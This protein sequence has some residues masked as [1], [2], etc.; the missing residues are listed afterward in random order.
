MINLSIAEIDNYN[1]F[2]NVIEK[3]RIESRRILNSSKSKIVKRYDLYCKKNLDIIFP[4]GDWDDQVKTHLVS[5]YGSNVGLDSAKEKI[6]GAFIKEMKFKC[7][8]CMVNSS[9]TFDHYFDKADYP[10]YSIFTPNLIPCCSQ[11]NS[12]K[13]T[14]MF[15]ANGE[16]LFIHFYYDVIPMNQFLFIRFHLD[17]DN[18]PVSEISLEFSDDNYSSQLIKRHFY[19]LDLFDRYTSCITEKLSTLLEEIISYRESFMMY[20]I[21]DIITKRWLSTIKIYGQNYLESSLLEGVLNSENFIENVLDC[22]G[23]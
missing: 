23:K 16:R 3:K 5:C 2:D 17:E 11:C 8:F 13:G 9:N 12:K 18:I 20:Q 21:K 15:N 7:P 19:S 4:T 22:Y 1:L 14:R 6:R 10:E